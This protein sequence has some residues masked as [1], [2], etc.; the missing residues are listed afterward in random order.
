MRRMAPKVGRKPVFEA[1]MSDV[2]YWDPWDTSAVHP[3][4]GDG[5][6]TSTSDIQQ[7]DTLR[8]WPDA[9]AITKTPALPGSS[10]RQEQVEASPMR[11]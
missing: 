5:L 9:L 1:A 3:Y 11:G 8:P 10:D 4:V 2:V 6:V 7:V